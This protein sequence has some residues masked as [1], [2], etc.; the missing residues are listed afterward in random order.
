MKG[1]RMQ[2][3][4]LVGQFAD[5]IAERWRTG[6]QH[7]YPIT[8]NRAW[9]SWRDRHGGQN[10]AWSCESLSQAAQHWCWTS[11]IDKFS[12]ADLAQGLQKAIAAGD[13]TL[14]GQLCHDIYGWGGV[15]LKPT[16]Q[17]YAWVQQAAQKGEL[18]KALR[19][20]VSL[21]SPESTLPLNRFNDDDLLMTSAT[22]KLYAAAAA[23]GNVAIY[24]GRVGA[25]LGLLARQFLE[26]RQI[27]FVPDV[28]H[29][30]WG[31][32][33]TAAQARARTRDPSTA[34]HVFRQ[35]PNGARSHGVRAELSR[36]T[37]ALFQAVTDRLLERHTPVTF[38]ELER[39]LFM[40]GYCVR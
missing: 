4:L 38:L 27:G 11:S 40:I 39:A 16:D 30:L 13:E 8:R 17:S 10:L 23:D 1:K 31:P 24:D 33:R 21:L 25:G 2:D 7:T 6:Y 14:A 36:R 3:V 9:N 29:F 28:L 34:C 35:L 22:T 26:V 32:P 37:N 12:F 5:F 19:D 15:A 18:T 20:A